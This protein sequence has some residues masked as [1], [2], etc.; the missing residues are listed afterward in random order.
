MSLVNRFFND[1]RVHAVLIELQLFVTIF[2]F[3]LYLCTGSQEALYFFFV[4]I[5]TAIM[6]LLLKFV[7]R[8]LMP[9]LSKRPAGASDCKSVAC[10]FQASD[11]GMPS[12]HSMGAT[13]MLVY[14][15]EFIWRRSPT[16]KQ[17]ELTTALLCLIAAMICVSRIIYK[18]HTVIQ[19]LAGILCGCAISA[20]A[21]TQR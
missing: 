15:L 8:L 5:C 17:K 12:G 18:C 16:L 20:V 4:L 7:C 3:L 10:S 6:T 1:Y 13:V 14:T 21:I 2:L 19:V 9:R 11:A